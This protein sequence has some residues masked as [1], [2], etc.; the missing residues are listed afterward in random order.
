MC[1]AEL[2][3]IGTVLCPLYCECLVLKAKGVKP[4]LLLFID[5]LPDHVEAQECK[6]VLHRDHRE[7]VDA[8]KDL[9][10]ILPK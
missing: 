7:I 3:A 10:T 1:L 5:N 2:K 6:T 9:S 8:L 4:Q